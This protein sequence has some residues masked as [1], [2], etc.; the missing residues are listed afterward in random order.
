MSY[1]SQVTLED[2]IS[3][4]NGIGFFIHTFIL[5][6]FLIYICIKLIAHFYRIFR[7]NNDF[8]PLL[9][10]VSGLLVGLGVNVIHIFFYV[11]TVDPTLLVFI[12]FVNSLYFIFIIRDL[13]L[14]LQL[15]NYHYILDNF[16]EMYLVIDVNGDVVDASDELK[17]KFALLQKENL[18]YQIAKKII[19]KDSIVYTHSEELNTTF[20]EQKVYL[21]MK[22]IKINLPLY[23]QSGRLFLFYNET[24]NIK[25]MNDMNYLMNHDIMTNLYNRNYFE[26]IKE[27][28][29]NSIVKYTVILFDLDGLKLFNDYLGHKA[30]DNLLKRFS[31]I[32][33]KVS[34]FKK[35]IIP[36]RLGGDEFLLIIEDASS[37]DENMIIEKVKG[38]AQNDKL[39]KN[40]GFSYGLASRSKPTD[41]I[42]VILKKADVKL[43]QMKSE[44]HHIKSKLK[45]H[46]E[47][48]RID[49][50]K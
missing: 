13:N 49:D 10:I 8:I 42:T 44:R 29:D 20:N 50:T 2:F 19:E 34:K 15:G 48:I 45:D 39:E 9:V 36:I 21:H 25:L 26:S 5:Y 16:R 31:S 35:K 27:T 41:K 47:K 3:S 30:G 7:K 6:T 46:L 33:S 28:I 22:E 24:K 14:I 32:L 43:Y 38:L 12:L 4:N 23:N 1:S 17:L 37:R 18:T 11:F 40:I